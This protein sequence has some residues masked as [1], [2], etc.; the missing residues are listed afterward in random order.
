MKPI[1]KCYTKIIKNA[2]VRIMTIDFRLNFFVPRPW[3]DLQ[4]RL[5]VRRK[6][7]QTILL[8]LLF[9]IRIC[10]IL[11]NYPFSPTEKNSFQIA[12][13]MH[14]IDCFMMVF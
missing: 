3:R 6:N 11:I 9:F 13:S 14:K 4:K 1:I 7:L 10:R 12:K 2:F 8:L 5:T